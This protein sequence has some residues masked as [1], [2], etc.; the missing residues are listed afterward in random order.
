MHRKNLLIIGAGVALLLPASSFSDEIKYVTSPA[1]GRVLAIQVDE[2]P[3]ITLPGE[4]IPEGGSVQ[5]A[6]PTRIC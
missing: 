3:P 1:T 6:A 5:A 2:S 4:E